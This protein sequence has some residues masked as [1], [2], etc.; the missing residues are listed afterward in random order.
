MSSNVMLM[1]MS[2]NVRILCLLS[3]SSRSTYIILNEHEQYN[4]Y[5]IFIVIEHEQY[6]WECYMQ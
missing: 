2:S 6:N 4:T 5:L 1:N 3:T